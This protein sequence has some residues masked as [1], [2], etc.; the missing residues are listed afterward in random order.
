MKTIHEKENPV[1]ENLIS[2]LRNRLAENGMMITEE[3]LEYTAERYAAM[4]ISNPE[5]DAGKLIEEDIGNVK[6]ILA[7]VNSSDG[8]E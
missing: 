5:L 4:I 7:K 6:A 3:S 8:V 2:F 1:R